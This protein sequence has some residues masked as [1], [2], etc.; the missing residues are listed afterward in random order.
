MFLGKLFG[1]LAIATVAAAAIGAH[2]FPEKQVQVIV[3]FAAGSSTDIAARTLA[4]GLSRAIN[5]GVAVENRTGAEGAIGARAVLSAPADG[6]VMMF[7]SSSVTVLDPLM[8]ANL[9][10]DPVNDFTPICTVGGTRFL[11]NITGASPYKTVADIIAAAKAAPGK[12]TFAYSSASTRLAG[13]LFQQ[14]AG[15]KFRGVPY[16]SSAQG[17]TEVAAGQ[18]D[19]FFID[20]PSAGPF[21]QS[22][23]IR[24]VVVSGTGRLKEFPDVPAAS[25]FGLADFNVTPWFGLYISGKTPAPILEQVRTAVSRALARPEMRESLEKRNILP[26]A[27]CGD[28]MKNYLNNEINVWR[29]VTKNAGIEPQ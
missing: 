7:T 13:E 8:R 14:V 18:V 17:L 15:V 23:K 16:R 27:H 26:F 1:K 25:E 20:T 28:A 11:L 5:Q 19:I 3:P 6:H 10:Y 21:Y 29:R 24:P 2:A 9:G 12:I 22:G 4:E